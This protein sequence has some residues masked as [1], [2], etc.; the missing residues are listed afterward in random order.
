MTRF[1]VIVA[2]L[3]WS[4]TEPAIY[5]RYAC[6]S[7]GQGGDSAGDNEE[8][9]DFK[10]HRLPQLREFTAVPQNRVRKFGDK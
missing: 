4:G 1:T 8:N 9:L 2:F 10:R 5:P 7:W 6:S 3:Q